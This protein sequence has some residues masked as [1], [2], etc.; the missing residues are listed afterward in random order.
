MTLNLVPAQWFLTELCHLIFENNEK[1]S[2]FTLLLLKWCILEY[3]SDISYVGHLQ[4]NTNQV[5]IKF[6]SDYFWVMPLELG[7]NKK[8]VVSAV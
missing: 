8:F 7:V 5:Q 4:E 1:F 2:V 6:W 3:K